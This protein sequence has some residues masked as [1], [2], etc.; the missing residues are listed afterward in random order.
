MKTLTINHDETEL[1]E[2]LFLVN[3]TWIHL[4]ESEIK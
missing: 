3:P 4:D 2:G 1:N